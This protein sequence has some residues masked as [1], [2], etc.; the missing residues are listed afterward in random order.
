V[1]AEADVGPAFAQVAPVAA[2]DAGDG[3]QAERERDR[4]PAHRAAG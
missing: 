3:N 4:E 2:R 1:P